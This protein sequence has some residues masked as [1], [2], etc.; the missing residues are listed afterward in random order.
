MEEK[1]REIPVMVNMASLASYNGFT[2]DPM[3]VMTMGRLIPWRDTM[4]LQYIESQKDEV[5][6][7]VM[8]SEIQLLMK[9][10]QVTMHRR[11]GEFQNT[12][13]FRRNKR[14][15]TVYQTPFGEIPMAVHTRDIRCDLGK[16]MGKLYLK[17]ELSMNGAYASTNE[18][19]LEYWAN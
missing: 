3:Q 9:K 18:L 1:I 19:H 16:S 2:D 13:M 11:G 10:D 15:E 5:T 4:Q 12:M 7:E 6:G 8:E 14:Y 17:Y